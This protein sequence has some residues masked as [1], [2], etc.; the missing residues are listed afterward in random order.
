[1]SAVT[2]CRLS[3]VN[4]YESVQQPEAVNDKF[5]GGKIMK[6]YKILGQKLAF[7]I[8]G[9]L[10][11]LTLPSTGAETSELPAAEEESET[12]D[13]G[14][15]SGNQPGDVTGSGS[16][17]VQD[18]NATLQHILGVK[19]LTEQQ[20]EAADVN[21]DGIINVLDVTLIMQFAIGLIDSLDN[22]SVDQTK[23]Q[24]PPGPKTQPKPDPLPG[25]Q[26][27]PKP[28]PEPQPDPQ[29]EPG[30]TSLQIRIEN[31]EHTTVPLKQ[32]DLAPYDISPVVG[33]NAAGSWHQGNDAP[34]VI[35][36]IIKVLEL[37]SFNVQDKNV[38]TV[39][40]GG[41]YISKID[42]L[43]EME[44]GGL[45]GWKY[46][47][48]GI[49]VDLGVGQQTLQNGDLVEVYYRAGGTYH[50]GKIEASSKEISSGATVTLTVTGQPDSFGAPKPYEPIQGA[51]I[52][53]DGKMTSHI[54]D[55]YGKAQITFSKPGTY[56][57]SAEKIEGNDYNLIRPNPVSIVVR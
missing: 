14:S 16:V 29:P 38:I 50:F 12:K 30:S 27:Q 53:I 57:I 17:N 6:R 19:I 13:E 25:P 28:G 3:I 23:T 21:K 40:S 56:Y 10:L 34:L 31:W 24:P 18:V 2:D 45:S 49:S 33:D 35:H 8:L 22:V 39:V 1:M 7:I 26:P 48:N 52:T 15:I 46:R 55:V 51:S 20:K 5:K 4:N 32:I 37:G 47:L 54:T 42:G 11:L 9:L 41:N 36:A 43:A 44:K